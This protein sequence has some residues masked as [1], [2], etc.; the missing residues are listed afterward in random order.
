MAQDSGQAIPSGGTGSRDTYLQQVFGRRKKNTGQGW[1]YQR[2][3]G[4]VNVITQLGRVALDEGRVE[5]A[6]DAGL[7]GAGVQHAEAGG[8]VLAGAQEAGHAQRRVL[9]QEFLCALLNHCDITTIYTI[10]HTPFNDNI[11]YDVDIT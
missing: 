4:E 1:F 3:F 6:A 11:P 9:V 10:L 2:G 7:R 8:A 5:R